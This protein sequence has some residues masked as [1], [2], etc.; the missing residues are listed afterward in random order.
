MPKNVI[1]WAYCS[2]IFKGVHF[3]PDGSVPPDE[4]HKPASNAMGPSDPSTEA[5]R[6]EAAPCR[7]RLGERDTRGAEIREV[8]WC[9]PEFMVYR[10]DDGVFACFSDDPETART[11]L[12][13]YLS[14]GVSLAEIEHLRGLWDDGLDFR[15]WNPFSWKQPVS[16][17]RKQI[18]ELAHNREVARC[19]AQ[20]LIG[21]V[22]ESKAGLSALRE[23]W[24]A[25][26]RNWMRVVHLMVNILLVLFVVIFCLTLVRSNYVSA[27]GFNAK[28]MTLASMMGAVGALFSTTVGLRNMAVDPSVRMIVHFVYALQR[29]MV[30]VLGAMVLYIGLRAGVLFELMAPGLQEAEPIGPSQ[31]FERYW[32]A[33]ASILAGFSERLVPNMLSSRSAEV[34]QADSGP[35]SDTTA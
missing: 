1:V 16:K 21:D 7:P 30:G 20:A 12:K 23:R 17:R 31:D 13:S 14:L 22:A 27:F 3:M 6:E 15:W 11:Q 26:N 5:L 25:Q 29:I 18:S 19:I 2:V 34:D 10:C 32:L 4:P 35:K 33:F 28:E 9:L 24:A 8:H